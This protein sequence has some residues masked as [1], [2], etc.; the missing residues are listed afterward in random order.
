MPSALSSRFIKL[1]SWIGLSLVCLQAQTQETFRF[2]GI[3]KVGDPPAA[4]QIR[5]AL[6]VGGMVA[7]VKVVTQ[8]LEGLDFQYLSDDCKA[9]YYTPQQ[10]CMVQVAFEPAVPGERRG[11]IVLLDTNNTVLSTQPLEANAAGSIATFVPGVITSVAGNAS[12]FIYGGDGGQATRASLFLPMGVTVDAANNIYIA[13]TYNNAIRRVDSQT[14]I[15]TTIVGN[16]KGGASGDG[17]PASAATLNLPS[18]VQLDAA[19]NLYIAD[20]GNNVIRVV[21]AASGTISTVAGTMGQHGYSGD[22]G[23]ATLAT[24]ES[25]HGITLDSDGD[26]YIADTGNNVIRLVAGSS[27]VIST[28]AGNGIAAYTGDNGAAAAASLN[29]PWGIS[30][31]GTGE[32][33]IADQNNN[34]I[35]KVSSAQIMSTVAGNGVAGFAGDGRIASTSRLNTPGGVTIDVAGNI[36]ISDSGNN[37]IRKI[38]SATQVISTI[39][40]SGGYGDSFPA[41]IASLYGPFTIALDGK[42]DLFIADSLHNRV[43]EIYSNIATL[44]YPLMRV[45][46]ASADMDQILENDGTAELNF[47]G[48]TAISMAQLNA[49]TTCNSGVQLAVLAQC[50]VDASFLP[51]TTG[52]PVTGSIEVDSDARNAEN[53]IIL[54]AQVQSTSPSTVLLSS[55]PN[56]ST[57]G[58]PILF[59][60]QVL[61]AGVIPTGQVNLLDGTTKIASLQL[62]NGIASVSISDLAVGQHTLTAA[63]DGDANS[64]SAT[65]LPLLQVVTVLPPN[66][67]TTTFLSSSA[68]PVALGQILTLT[69]TVSAVTSGQAA[70]SGSVTLVEGSTVLGTASLVGGVGNFSISTLSVGTHLIG[71]V[72]G[73]S[74]SYATSTSP[75]LTELV[76]P[77][78][79]NTSTPVTLSVTPPAI[80]L[81]SGAHGTLQ[82]VITTVGTFSDTLSLG[83]AGIPVAATCTFSEGQFVVSGS[84]TKNISL[85]VDTGNPL[86][87]GSNANLRQPGSK[88]GPRVFE[89]LLPFSAFLAF[90]LG[91]KR[92]G[93]HYSR[94]IAMVV[95]LSL[96]TVLSGCGS[97]YV[98]KTTPPATYTLEIVATGLNTGANVSVPVKL[99]VTN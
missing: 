31:A 71:A 85:I 76:V 87:S 33:Y 30:L 79:S 67:S 98:V 69:A 50:N 27:G 32:L 37:R 89:F 78:G 11:A 23:K 59:S 2:A 84:T 44:V 42:G 43:R 25:P 38:N 12:T 91:K 46:T 62:A 55:N 8:G 16:G 93:V 73:G 7:K 3:R 83:C 95:A 64:G 99:T 81:K 4:Q 47:S 70:P 49:G 72:Y 75:I 35:R 1:L 6:P 26:L 29:G 36:Y 94:L 74:T 82:L 14:G 66:S 17:G 56:P 20:T 5:V 41:N 97:S 24:L 18:S 61:S 15:I 63:Y 57:A 86:G 68:N 9:R 19:G 22:S 96:V 28:I 45:N 39:A 54:Q 48:T 51:T 77:A 34:A 80:S 40:G 90:S 13:D 58:N 88:S 21:N 92:Q 60:V 52:N 53:K 10:S 65:S